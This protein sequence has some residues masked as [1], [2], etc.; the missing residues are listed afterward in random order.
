[1]GNFWTR[2]EE[3][4]DRFRDYSLDHVH[5]SHSLLINPYMDPMS[6]SGII[7]LAECEFCGWTPDREQ[8]TQPCVPKDG[9]HRDF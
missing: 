7:E 4:K 3:F 8:I 5:P 6:A 1:M 9:P 2:L